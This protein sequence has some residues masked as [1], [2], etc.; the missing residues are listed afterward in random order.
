MCIRDSYKQSYYLCHFLEVDIQ[1]LQY[2]DLIQVN[3]VRLHPV[4]DILCINYYQKK[5]SW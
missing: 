2:F 4:E 3:T 5:Y 1:K